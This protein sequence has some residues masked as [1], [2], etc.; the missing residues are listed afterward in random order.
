[1]NV[2]LQ[3]VIRTAS[4]GSLSI[5]PPEARRPVAELSSKV[6]VV[7]VAVDPVMLMAPPLPP[8]CPVEVLFAWL[9][10]NVLVLTVSEGPLLSMAPPLEP[11]GVEPRAATLLVKVDPLTLRLPKF[12]MPPPEPPST[13]PLSARARLLARTTWSRFRVAPASFRMPPPLSPTVSPLAIVNRS[14][15]TVALLLMSKTRLRLFPLRVR[16]FSPRP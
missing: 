15:V 4:L 6:Q 7:T 16:W 3:M 8:L 1:M 14:M 9:F 10:E 5:A 2:L 12:S 13:P 11:R